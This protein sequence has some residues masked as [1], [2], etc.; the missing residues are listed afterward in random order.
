MKN[1]TLVNYE[2]KGDNS[3]NK[4]VEII[5]SNIIEAPADKFK[6]PE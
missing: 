5:H 3:K 1:M 6:M 2:V 4:N